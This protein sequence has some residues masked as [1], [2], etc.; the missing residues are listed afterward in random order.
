MKLSITAVWVV[1]LL[2]AA[3]GIFPEG[4]EFSGVLDSKVTMAAGAGAAPEFSWGFEEYANLR[5]QAKIR[6]KAVFYGALNLIAA[7][8][9]SAA[10]A[11][12]LGAGNA[13]A[14]PGLT[15]SSFVAGENYA[16][17]LELERLYFRVT[18]DAADFDAGLMRLGFGYSLVFG[19]SDF[20]NPRN[21]LR[22]DARLRGI[23]GAAVS[24][25]P[26]D[27][28]KV[29]AFAVGPKNPLATE[30]SG[31]L[32]G[33]SWDQHG[34]R[35]SIQALYAYETP[36]EGSPGGIHRGG[37]SLKADA[38]VGLVADMLY[39]YNPEGDFS[40]GG[41]A[42]AAGLD[43]SFFEGKLYTLAEYLYSGEGSATARSGRNYLYASMTYRVS[44]YTTGSLACMAGLDDVSFTPILSLEHVI[45]QG[46]T[47]SL[48]AQVPLDRDL[49]SGDGN[50]GELGPLP[51][52]AE[53]GVYGS[54]SAQVRLR[55]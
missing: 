3:G 47:L 16:A 49:F 27:D 7:T 43:Y 15:S 31:I 12:M 45:F 54:F 32:A 20:L 5:M 10:G 25:Y 14:Y 29:L 21:P 42:A 23:L 28:A 53:E 33:L 19:P 30:G 13:V 50:R 44:D 37:L 35:L 41:L 8:G 18:S 2:G 22:P 39:T 51:P 26:N 6:D 48:S 40:I 36:Q 46:L 17:A 1:A 55:F 52:G 24:I 34:E 38:A 9:S 11:V 4:L